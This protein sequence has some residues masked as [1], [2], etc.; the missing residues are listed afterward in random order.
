MDAAWEL[1]ITTFDTADAY[2]GGRSETWIG[3][4]LA[5]KGSAVRDAI[6][7]ETKTFNPM[8]AGADR[9]LSRDRIRRQVETSLER[10]GLE[11]IRSTWRTRSTRTPPRRRR[12]R[13]STSSCA[14]ARSARSARRTSPAEQLA[15]AVE[16]SELRGLHALRVG[17][18]LVLAARSRRRGDGLP[19]LPRAR[20]RLRGVRPA[21]GRLAHRVATGGARLPRGLADDP[22]ARRVPEVRVRRGVRRPRGVR[23]RGARARRLDGRPRDRLAPR[24][25][26]GQRRRGRADSGRAS[27]TGSRGAL[28]WAHA[29]DFAHLRGLFA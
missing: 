8:E 26:R 24:R 27:R 13:R 28:A 16:I 7:I 22:A 19:R 21:R 25:A 9:G 6:T 4:W 11:R 17:A 23:A 2:G 1:G 29:D 14:R 12:S 15:E 3:E 10:L 5:T 18:E 20:A